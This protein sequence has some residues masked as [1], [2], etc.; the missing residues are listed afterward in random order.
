WDGAKNGVATF[1]NEL[2]GKLLS[3]FEVI[4]SVV[5]T[6]VD[7][8]GQFVS[9]IMDG[10]KS[11]GGEVNTLST[12]FLGFNPVLKIAMTIFSQFGPQI[13]AGFSQVASMVV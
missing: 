5:T 1:A 13:A 8:I 9:S 2:G 6:V 12:L 7:V 10:F 11:A 4:S 3:A